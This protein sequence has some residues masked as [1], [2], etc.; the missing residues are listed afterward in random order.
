[1]FQNGTVRG[2]CRGCGVR[3]G[4]WGVVWVWCGV[5]EARCVGGSGLRCGVGHG[6]CIM[7]YIWDVEICEVGYVGA[8]DVAWRVGVG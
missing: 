5:E 1:M 6:P 7:W 2:A 3:C 8:R 4:L